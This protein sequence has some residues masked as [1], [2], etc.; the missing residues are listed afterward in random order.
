M[1][2]VISDVMGVIL[3]PFKEMQKMVTGMFSD[4]A[5]TAIGLIEHAGDELGIDTLAGEVVDGV[6]AIG[7]GAGNI[8][9]KGADTVFGMADM[10]SYVPMIALGI[11]GIFVLSNSKQLLGIGERQMNRR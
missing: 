5:E 8:V 6:S 4:Q 9:N 3:T 7:E 10:M 2:N 11:G 1:G